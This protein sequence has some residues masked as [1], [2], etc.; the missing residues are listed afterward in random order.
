MK[1]KE[2]DT[3]DVK[4]AEEIAD[5]LVQSSEGRI[6]EK[7]ALD[8]GLEIVADANDV[9]VRSTAVKGKC[10]KLQL[11]NPIKGRPVEFQS[12]CVIDFFSRMRDRYCLLETFSEQ[13]PML[14]MGLASGVNVGSIGIEE[15]NQSLDTIV[16]FPQKMKDRIHSI[17][18][19]DDIVRYY[20]VITSYAVINYLC[21]DNGKLSDRVDREFADCIGIEYTF[22]TETPVYDSN[23]EHVADTLSFE[24]L[25]VIGLQEEGITVNNLSA[26]VSHELIHGI[27]D[28]IFATM[29]EL[30]DYYEM[31]GNDGLYY[32][33]EFLCDFIP[34]DKL[35]FTRYSAN[36]LD[37]MSETLTEYQEDYR[38]AYSEIILA[39]RPFYDALMLPAK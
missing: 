11:S 6:P 38:N 34:H 17:V 22:T 23:G 20:R 15:L 33:I 9:S 7:R 27:I 13:F 32:M 10:N 1:R 19:D 14:V 2:L 16:E 29:P 28:S 31:L 30:D 21:I 24:Y 36:P 37:E 39:L 26:V 12:D 3:A 5:S 35:V 18:R 25:I 8:L 4:Q